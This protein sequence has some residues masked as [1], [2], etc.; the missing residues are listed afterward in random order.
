MMIEKGNPDP[1]LNPSETV[2]RLLLSPV[3]DSSVQ[4]IH[5][6]P[7]YTNKILSQGV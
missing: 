5:G 6:V 3:L 7:F 4:E 2:S 1:L